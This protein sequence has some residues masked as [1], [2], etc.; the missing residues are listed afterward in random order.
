[1]ENAHGPRNPSRSR[2]QSAVTSAVKQTS[3]VIEVIRLIRRVPP[4]NALV[5][6]NGRMAVTSVDERR[7]RPAEKSQR[8]GAPVCPPHKEGS[9]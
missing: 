5:A 9:T 3:A 8:I 1:M 7:E 6:G 2:V 4:H